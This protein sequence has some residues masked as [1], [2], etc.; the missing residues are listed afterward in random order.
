MEPVSSLVGQ[1]GFLYTVNVSA[2]GAVGASWSLPKAEIVQSQVDCWVVRN[3]ESN[4]ECVSRDQA[5]PRETRKVMSSGAMI[6]VDGVEKGDSEHNKS[7]ASG[8]YL[9]LA[10]KVKKYPF[11]R[12]TDP[13]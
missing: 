10:K 4:V 2:W 1:V 12:I 13:I 9:N 7:E 8:L 6:Y 5:C 3:D 11:H